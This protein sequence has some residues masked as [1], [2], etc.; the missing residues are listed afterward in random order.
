LTHRHPPRTLF[1]YDALPISERLDASHDQGR[2]RQ[3]HLALVEPVAIDLG[4]AEMRDQIV[5]RPRAALGDDAR[6]IVL[7]PIIGGDVLRTLD[8]KST[9]LTP[10]TSLSRI[11][12]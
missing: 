12:S 5:L 9:R 11:P 10:V 4:H 1:P 3:Q 8:R 2:R 6:R 7:H